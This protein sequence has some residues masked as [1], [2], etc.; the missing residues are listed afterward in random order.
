MPCDTPLHNATS[1]IVYAC[2][3]AAVETTICNG[4]VLMLDREIPGETEILKN[5]AH[6]AAGLVRRAQ[7]P[8]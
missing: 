2:S 4:R 6:A 7:T 1:N 5:A 3:G 8:V